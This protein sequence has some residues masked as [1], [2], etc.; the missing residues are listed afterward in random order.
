[1]LVLPLDN[2]AL[3]PGYPFVP[4][5][6]QHNREAPSVHALLS[7]IIFAATVAVYQPVVLSVKRTV[8]CLL[9]GLQYSS[10]YCMIG[11]SNGRSRRTLVLGYLS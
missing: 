7:Q 5:H 1:M 8:G 3:N 10:Y 9:S 4:G 6:P 2:L 11:E